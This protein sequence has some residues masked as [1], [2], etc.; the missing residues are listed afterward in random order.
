MEN[1]RMV[2]R[3]FYRTIFECSSSAMG[4]L[5]EDGTVSLANE[6]L[7]QAVGWSVE[8]IEGRMNWRSWILPEEPER[9]ENYHR[10]RRID[11]ESVPDQYECDIKRKDGTIRHMLVRVGMIPQTKKSILSAMDVTEVRQMEDALKESENRFRGA[12]EASVTGIVLV[13]LDGR[14][15]KVNR[16][17]CDSLGYSREEFLTKR[18]QE[19][20]HPDDIENDLEHLKRLIDDQIPHYQIEKRYYHSDGYIVWG[21]LSVSLVRDSRGCPLYFVGQMQDITER[22]FFEE[23]L[24]TA[25][26]TDELTGLY[27]RRGFFECS[28]LRLA[29]ASQKGNIF[30]LFLLK[31]NHMIL[32][33]HT[34]GHE[35]GDAIIKAVGHMLQRTFQNNVI[36]RI[37][38][39]EFAVLVAGEAELEKAELL[40]NIMLF[41]KGN[42]STCPISISVRTADWRPEEALSL[43]QLLARANDAKARAPIE[44]PMKT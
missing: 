6:R 14:F 7:S 31:L 13:G 1:H 16:A 26:I 23:R 43:E 35:Q 25:L 37:G 29:R 19:I 17:Y 42:S 38:G 28:Q 32:L 11:P 34:L 41:E 44:T 4:V 2:S 3:N 12:F 21:L 18:F 9:L 10:S 30:T 20:T 40:H 36:G 24:E 8:E 33:N 15:L 5:E 27:N 39:V 22:K